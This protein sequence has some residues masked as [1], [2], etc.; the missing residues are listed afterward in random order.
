MSAA[1]KLKDPDCS[2]IHLISEVF[3]DESFDDGINKYNNDSSATNNEFY[4]EKNRD[5]TKENEKE[6]RIKN[7]SY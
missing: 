4:V 3:R 2:T 7:C 5:I 6:N 1:H